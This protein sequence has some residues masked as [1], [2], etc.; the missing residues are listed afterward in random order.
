MPAENWELLFRD[1]LIGWAHAVAAD[2]KEVDP[3]LLGARADQYRV[4]RRRVANGAR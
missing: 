2:L 1:S 3:R 4:S